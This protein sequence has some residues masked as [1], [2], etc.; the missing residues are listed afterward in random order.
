MS[1][2]GVIKTIRESQRDSTSSPPENTETQ[3]SNIS[4]TQK[5]E[6]PKRGRP[7]AKR[8]D[9]NYKQVTAYI[10]KATH[11]EVKKRLLD[12]EREFSELVEELL[13]EWLKT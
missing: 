10:L 9:D 12:E 5:D 2:F 13:A 1:K 4:A 6:M 3:T 11:L 8:S 7:R